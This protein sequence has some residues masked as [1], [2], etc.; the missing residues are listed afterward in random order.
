MA[1]NRDLDA[2]LRAFDAIP[3]AARKPIKA[4]LDK[5]GKEMVDRMKY[6][7]PEKTG[8]L[9]STIAVEPV[10]DVAIRVVAGGEATTVPVREGQSATFDYALGQE[11]G[12][13]DMPA[14]PFFRPAINTTKTRVRRRVD[15]AVGKAV[16]DAWEGSK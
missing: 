5:G 2:I 9:K 13:I 14:N 4:A 16:K 11:A 12:T 15:R 1:R 8:R 3:K 7:A 6:L 10:S